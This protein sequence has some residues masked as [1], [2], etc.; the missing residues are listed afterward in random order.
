SASRLVLL[1]SLSSFLFRFSL[2]I[3]PATPDLSPLSLHDALP[4]SGLRQ[5]GLTAEQRTGWATGPV[6]PGRHLVA[7][8]GNPRGRQW[9]PRGRSEEHT[10]ELQSLTNLVCRLLLEK[11][12]QHT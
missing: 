9:G 8:L 1:L 10:S 5:E 2:F 12:K 3:D 11:K 6:W 4:I 7:V